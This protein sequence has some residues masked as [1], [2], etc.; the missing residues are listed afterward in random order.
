M[1]RSILIHLGLALLVVASAC[2]RVTH[3]SQDSSAPPPVLLPPPI[4]AAFEAANARPE[5]WTVTAYDIMP[6]D[7]GSAAARFETYA[8]D[9]TIRV[10]SARTAELVRLLGT[11]AGYRAGKTAC[12]DTTLPPLFGIRVARGPVSLDLV[13]RCGSR[14]ALAAAVDNPAEGNLTEEAMRFVESLRPPPPPPPPTV[15]HVP[16]PPS[17]RAAFGAANERSEPWTATAYDLVLTK[18]RSRRPQFATFTIKRTM[19]VP[20]QRIDELVRW[21]STDAGYVNDGY[22]CCPV[23]SWPNALGLRLARGPVVLDFVIQCGQIALGAPPTLDDASAVETGYLASE[24][25]PVLASLY[26][27]GCS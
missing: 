1:R 11:D 2:R 13:V 24:V 20:A 5:P 12:G 16:P 18:R 15:S 23:A 17:I 21:L 25:I 26:K 19:S 3:E 6:G 9:R 8:I 27:R 10:P 22:A 7:A 4:R 14:V